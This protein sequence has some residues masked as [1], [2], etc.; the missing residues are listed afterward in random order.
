MRFLCAV[1]F[2][3]LCSALIVAGER[4]PWQRRVGLDVEVRHRLARQSVEPKI[5]P[6]EPE[7]PPSI[8]SSRFKHALSSLCGSMPSTRLEMY[9]NSILEQSQAF[10]VDP[11]I[12]GALVYDQSRCL[13]RTP[14]RETRHGV[15]RVDL[16]MHAPHIRE[17]NYTFFV[18]EKKLWEKRV[19]PVSKYPFNKWKLEKIPSN[20]YF[21]AAILRMF[22][23]QCADLDRFCPGARHRHPISH[24][25]FGDR[26]RDSEP[27]DR[28]LT[29]R[30]RL[31]QYYRQTPAKEAGFFKNIPLV[32]PLDGAPRLVI[33]YF[34]NRRGKKSGPGHRGIDIVGVLG[35][36]VH[37]IAAGRVSFAGVDL[38]G[39]ETSAILTPEQAAIDPA[40]KMGRGGLYIRINH[41]NN[42]GSIYMHLNTIAVHVG[43]HV[44]AGEKIGT[45][46]RSGTISSGPHLHLE[47][48]EGPNRVDPAP[49]LS[50][51]LANP[52]VK[53][54]Y[55]H[56]ESTN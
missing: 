2:I 1:L 41:D 54:L 21:S 11:F 22:S 35:E 31:L 17:G 53:R 24:W 16:S 13:P 26:V 10:E 18:R 32:S 6:D 38:P 39:H 23:I 29:A 27:E 50:D 52:Y 19:I 14:D 49:W 47:I 42:T 20:V 44:A 55:N 36:P 3:Q 56:V 40:Q 46:G 9:T 34:G 43:A 15:T 12:L 4:A 45:V 51:A 30:R 7:T 37:A 8:D 48:S 25:F 28:V 33:D 5:W